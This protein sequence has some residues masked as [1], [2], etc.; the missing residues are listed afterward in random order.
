[1]AG[2]KRPSFLKSQKEQKRKAK[3]QEK[4]EARQNKRA[5]AAEAERAEPGATVGAAEPHDDPGAGADAPD[6]GREPTS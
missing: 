4:R 6:N 3:A 2:T 5:R 1:M